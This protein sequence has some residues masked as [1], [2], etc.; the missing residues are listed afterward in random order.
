[1]SL[2]PLKM[3]GKIFALWLLVLSEIFEYRSAFRILKS[4]QSVPDASYFKPY[5]KVV[6]LKIKCF[7]SLKTVKITIIIPGIYRNLWRC[8]DISTGK[9]K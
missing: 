6:F 1:M 3:K 8:D 9:N 2:F 4:G 5:D 7:G